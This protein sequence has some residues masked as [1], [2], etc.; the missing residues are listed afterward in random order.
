MSQ[1]IDV[2]GLVFGFVGALILMLTTGY[3]KP[4]ELH[5]INEADVRELILTLPSR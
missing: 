3:G 5:L 1:W 2:T 4:S